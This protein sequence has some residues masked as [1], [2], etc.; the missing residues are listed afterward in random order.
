MS[1]DADLVAWEEAWRARNPEVAAAGVAR[2]FQ[3]ALLD[4]RDIRFLAGMHAGRIVAVVIAN[5]S[6]D[7][8]EPVVGISNIVL[9]AGDGETHRA[10]VI[11]AVRDAF[12]GLPMVGYE[13]GDDLAAMQG[14]GFRPLGSLRVWLTPR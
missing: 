4:D 11:V 2:L 9:T 14:L 10:G 13:R 8:T 6:D 1:R 5:R 7:G 12:P 3:P